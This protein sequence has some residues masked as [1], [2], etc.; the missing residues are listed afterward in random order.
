MIDWPASQIR[1]L[2]RRLLAWTRRTRREMPWRGVGD[3][4]R[5]WISEIMLQQT[6]VAAVIPYYERFLTRFPTLKS[7][8]DADEQDV[9]SAWEGLGYYSRGRNLHRAARV[10]MAEHAGEFPKTVHELRELPGI[11][12]YTAGAIASFAFD[13][14]APILEANTLR[15]YAR[16][17][18][19]AADPRTT[20]GQ[21]T[22]WRFAEEIVPSRQAGAFN[23]G[24]IDLG[25]L[26]CTPVDPQ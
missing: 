10:V 11:G 7:L 13:V 22:L 5:V 21:A 14:S 23:Q 25:A 18:G 12:R 20:E 16:L 24:A 17:M 4:Y 19:Y 9:L 8:A 3:A 15:L 2:R 1:Q 6:T 26:V